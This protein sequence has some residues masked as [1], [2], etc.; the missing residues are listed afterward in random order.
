ME[1]LL[2]EKEALQSYFQLVRDKTMDLCRPLENEDYVIQCS[3][4]VSPIKWHLGHTTWFF[5]E[6]IL[7]QY[8]ASYRMFNPLYH[9]LFNS[10]YRTIGN[11][12]PKNNRGFFSRPLVKEIFDYRAFVEERLFQSIKKMDKETWNHCQGLIILGLHHEQQHQELLL[13]DIKYNF[14][15]S[16][17]FPSYLQDSPQ[18]QKDNLPG[19]RGE[20]A[21]TYVEGGLV[22]IGHNGS[23]FAFDNESPRHSAILRPYLIANQLVSNREYLEFIEDG[24][25]QN[26]KWWLAE[27]FDLISKNA[28]LAPL[29]WRKNDEENAW[30]IFTLS[31]LKP[32]DGD[33]PVSHISYFEAYAFANWAGARLPTEVEWEY[34]VQSNGL[35]SQ[36]GNFLEAGILHPMQTKKSEG[37]AQFLGDLWEWTS[38]AYAAYPGFKPHTGS[39]GEY[40]GKFMSG[41]MVLKGGSCVTPESHIRSSYRNFY[42]PDKR[43]QFSGIR[44]AKDQ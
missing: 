43:W 37:I 11:P 35:Q 1:K 10:Y 33:E 2:K 29:Y 24:G 28:W 40:N 20:T 22:D 27:G 36:N 19:S 39:L 38:S 41:Q 6:F 14:S 25:Y 5:E 17:Y 4:D 3:E 8:D 31:G 34:F 12:Y 26:P 15:V 18:L 32:L 44:L 42:Q 23:G 7:S 13:M 30:E 9:Q 21:F 16:P